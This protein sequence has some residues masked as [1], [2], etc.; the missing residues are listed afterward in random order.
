M[1]KITELAIV[2]NSEFVMGFELIGIKKIFEGETKE[3]LKDRFSNALADSKIGI[4]V[5]N[6]KA[7]NKLDSA[8][9]R[10]VENSVTPV[11]VVL[12]TESFAQE[13]LRDMIKK[14]IGIDLLR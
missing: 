12:S 8:T 4:V 9:R 6:D 13:N 11:V 3:Q 2:G 5:T 7:V 1:I 14:A 10:Q